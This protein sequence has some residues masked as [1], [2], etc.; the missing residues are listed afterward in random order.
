MAGEFKF[1]QTIQFD[2]TNWHLVYAPDDPQTVPPNIEGAQIRSFTCNPVSVPG[3]PT[4]I[5]IAIADIVFPPQRDSA[6]RLIP[7]RRLIAFRTFSRQPYSPNDVKLN[8][9][10]YYIAEMSAERGTAA[11]RFFNALIGYS[12]D[13]IQQSAKDDSWCKDLAVIQEVRNEPGAISAH[14]EERAVSD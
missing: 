6:G 7:E 13:A 14:T 5:F 3:R 4:P 1:P 11:Q 12:P 8:E 10:A 9:C 2:D